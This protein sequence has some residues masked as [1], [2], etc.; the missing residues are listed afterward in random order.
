MLS[1]SL[2]PEGEDAEDQD[3]TTQALT[4]RALD[5]DPP[6]FS[7]PSCTSE[8]TSGQRNS[9]GQWYCRCQACGCKFWWA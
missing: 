6:A 2:K 1:K 4:E 8:D 7:C 3:M 9:D 5:T